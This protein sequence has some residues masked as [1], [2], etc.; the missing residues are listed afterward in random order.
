MKLEIHL[1]FAFSDGT[2]LA[3]SKSISTPNFD[4]SSVHGCVITTSNLRKRT[5]AILELYFRFRFDLLIVTGIVIMQCTD[6]GNV[7]I[8][9]PT[10]PEIWRGSQNFKSRSR[11][12]FLTSLT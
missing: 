5:S 6:A 3:M 8:L 12:P 10:V 7:K 2:P 1:D 9:A 4:N 11:D